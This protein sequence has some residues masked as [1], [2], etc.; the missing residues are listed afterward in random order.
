MMDISTVR[1]SEAPGDEYRLFE[2]PIRE[3]ATR[4]S[5][6]PHPALLVF[7][8]TKWSYAAT[9]DMLFVGISEAPGVDI[10]IWRS[11]FANTQCEAVRGRTPLC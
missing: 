7:S 9:V 4:G 2:V 5:Q 1:I 10:A 8:N 6:R 11:Q 3:Y